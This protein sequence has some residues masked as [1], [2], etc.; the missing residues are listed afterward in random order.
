VTCILAEPALAQQRPL[1]TEDPET[2]GSGR[3]LIEAGLDYA[4]DITFPLSGLTGNLLSVPTLGLSIGVSSIAEIQLDN[5]LYRRLEITERRPAPLAGLLDIDGTQTTALEDLVVATKVRLVSEGESRPAFGVRIATK[6][7][8]A[9]N[10]SGL[11][12]ET[13]DF[14]A[15]M[16]VG[17]T[18][19]SVRVVGNVGVTILDDPTRP[20]RQDALMS[21]GLSL[22]RALTTS[23]EIVGEVTGRLNFADGIA[24]PGAEN[25]GMF[26]FGARYTRGPVRIDGAAI[27]GLTSRDPDIGFTTGVTWVV[28]AFRVP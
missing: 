1:V 20:A 11:G 8:T 6:L 24:P 10:E 25:R 15:S 28:D 12:H 3:L 7:P 13:I 16:L 2:I 17:K 18:I 14:F 19:A 9:S 26:R 21:L 4:R 5:G 27:V 23:T 22:A